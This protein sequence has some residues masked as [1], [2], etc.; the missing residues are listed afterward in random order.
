MKILITGVGITGKSTFRRTLKR[1]ISIMGMS[2]EDFDGDY[3]EE[4]IPKKF[5]EETVYIIEDVHGTPETEETCLPLNAYDLIIYLLPT[6][7]SH[8]IFWL[9]RV[10]IWFQ[11]GKGSWDK[12]RKSWLGS[13]K[14]YDPLNIPLFLGL[15]IHDF[16]NR[17]MWINRDVKILS[18]F[19]DLAI[20]QPQ[21][22]MKGIKF[23]L[24]HH[25]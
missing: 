11:E 14:K 15:L 6:P 4:E 3:N 13:G 8:L 7:A 1:L 20:V 2:V 16:R 17:R 23:N 25:F 9:S 21:W 18:Q 5:K 12:T 24:T 10:W 22:T 19:R